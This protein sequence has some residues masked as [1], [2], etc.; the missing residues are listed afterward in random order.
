[1]QLHARLFGKFQLL[2]I[3]ACGLAKVVPLEPG[4]A[5]ELLCFVMLA[6]KRAHHRE[7]LA[8]L[9][10]TEGSSERSLKYLRQALWQLQ[11]LLGQYSDPEQPVLTVDNDWVQLNAA[12]NLWIDTSAFEAACLQVRNQ[13]GNEFSPEQATLVR[14]AAVLYSTDLLEGWHQDWCLTERERLQNRYLSTL[15]KLMDYCETHSD[16]ENGLDYGARILAIDK[17]RECT[18]QRLMRLNYLAG[19]RTAALRQYNRCS[20][21][22]REELNVQ[23]SKKTQR[24][25]ELIQSDDPENVQ[26]SLTS[27][28]RPGSWSQL[29]GELEQLH[30]LMREIQGQIEVVRAANS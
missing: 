28:S 25:L 17:A 9:F 1:M 11:S 13:S 12:A 5:R 6:G 18:H 30:M 26:V 20:Q 3:S 29:L 10:W 7:A 14:E 27:T 23:P 16:F 21:A 4:K 22:L 2:A 8:S 19:N 24:I 15:D